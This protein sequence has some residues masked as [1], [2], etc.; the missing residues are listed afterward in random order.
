MAEKISA[1]TFQTW[2]AFVAMALAVRQ[3]VVKGRKLIATGSTVILVSG[4]TGPFALWTIGIGT[5]GRLGPGSQKR[6]AQ[7]PGWSQCRHS[8]DE[9]DGDSP[10]GLIR[11]LK[12]FQQIFYSFEVSGANS[13]LAGPLASDGSPSNQQATG[14]ARAKKSVNV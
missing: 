13:V 10:R 4:T 8:F 12:A 2:A 6:R 11:Q 1:A 9:W 3:R 5:A 14:P 7:A